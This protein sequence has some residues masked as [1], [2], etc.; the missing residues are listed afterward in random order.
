MKTVL[1]LFIAF[2]Y[3]IDLFPQWEYNLNTKIQYGDLLKAK[4]TV[5]NTTELL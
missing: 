3:K 1:F 2:Y 5:L 4:Q